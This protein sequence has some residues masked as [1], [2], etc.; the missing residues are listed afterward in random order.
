MR[1]RVSKGP[2][3]LHEEQDVTS[4]V[5]CDSKG[6]PLMLALEMPDGQIFM[7]NASEASFPETLRELKMEAP[8]SYRSVGCPS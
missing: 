3:D 2:G 6:N 1:L 5:V 7:K 8:A 4:L